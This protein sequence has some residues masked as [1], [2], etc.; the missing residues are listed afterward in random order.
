MK[1]RIVSSHMLRLWPGRRVEVQDGLEWV[2][3][4]ESRTGWVNGEEEGV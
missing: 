2:E 4:N 1:V 3:L